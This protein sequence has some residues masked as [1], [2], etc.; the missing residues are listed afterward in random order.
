MHV[1]RQE[2]LGPSERKKYIKGCVWFRNRSIFNTKDS[3][4]MIPPL[5]TLIQIL[6]KLINF[7]NDETLKMLT[8]FRYVININF[9][10]SRFLEHFRIKKNDI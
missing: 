8:F 10:L 2:P 4:K 3:I 7:P 9:C 1:S 5:K 6:D